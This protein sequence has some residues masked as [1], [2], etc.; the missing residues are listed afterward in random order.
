ME[1]RELIVGVCGAAAAAGSG[2]ASGN[3]SVLSSREHFRELLKR[4][5]RVYDDR[6]RFLDELQLVSIED[7]PGAKGLE[8]FDLVFE[9]VFGEGLSEGSYVLQETR[10]RRSYAMHLQERERTKSFRATFSL[11]A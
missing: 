3:S 8:Q 2:T 11:L 7:G 5:F 9:G 4:S 10:S 6:S 1:R